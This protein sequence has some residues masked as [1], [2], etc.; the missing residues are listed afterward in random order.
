MPIITTFLP[1]GY[2][3]LS[4]DFR[5][6]HLTQCPKVVDASDAARSFQSSC[7]NV[8]W[9][10]REL[11]DGDDRA[12]NQDRTNCHFDD[13]AALFF[14]AN[15]KC[16]DG[17]VVLIFQLVCRASLFFH[18]T[19]LLDRGTGSN[20]NYHQISAKPVS[21]RSEI[22]VCDHVLAFVM[23]IFIRCGEGFRFYLVCPL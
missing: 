4:F 18:D 21:G 1:R 2:I 22:F 23:L 10:L 14:R 8:D 13:V 7:R 17:F 20:D 9:L 3:S 12:E 15:Q 5:T 16:V 6:S 19:T 11:P